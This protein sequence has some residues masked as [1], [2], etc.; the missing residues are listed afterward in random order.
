MPRTRTDRTR[1]AAQQKNLEAETNR[2][3]IEVVQAIARRQVKVAPGDHEGGLAGGESLEQDRFTRTAAKEAELAESAFE[4]S[5]AT[6]REM[7]E[8]LVRSSQEA[9]KTINA[10]IAATLEEIRSLG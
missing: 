5:V 10:R 2:V 7:A 4:K 8:I 6:M 1:F 9:T 3:A